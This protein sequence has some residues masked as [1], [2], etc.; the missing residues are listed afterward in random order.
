MS[1]KKSVKPVRSAPKGAGSATFAAKVRA[2]R[3]VLN[4]NQTELAVRSGLTQRA[5]YGI[6][7]EINRPRKAT[8]S[9]ILRALSATGLR[10]DDT[11]DGGFTLT[12]PGVPTQQRE[13]AR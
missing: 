8:E 10:I 2:A 9:Q 4:W 3:A 5:V 1:T 11:S 12:V 7:A 6:E 13:K